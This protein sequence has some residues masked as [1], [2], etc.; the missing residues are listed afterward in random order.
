[1]SPTFAAAGFE[2]E[3]QLVLAGPWAGEAR[4]IAARIDDGD[5]DSWLLE[6]TAAGGAA[7]AA[8]RYAEAAAYYAAALAFVDASDGS[9]DARALEERQHDCWMR[10]AAE[11]GGTRLPAGW[12]FAA[13]EDK[14]P[15]AVID[16]GA[17][18]ACHALPI[19][20]A[21]AAH[22]WNWMTNCRRPWEDD[23]PLPDLDV[24]RVALIE[25]DCRVQA[26]LVE[27]LPAAARSALRAGD[28]DA[29]DRELHLAELFAPGTAAGLAWRARWFDRGGEPLYD[30]YRR[31]D[32]ALVPA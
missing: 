9:V 15:L 3:L 22:G 1:V 19:G 32:D 2:R 18:P 26:D 11:L 30:V 6:W 29:F 10:G 13:G 8:A 25:L 21:L 4:L 17:R 14:R 24:A 23:A 5:P 31:L 20:T 7:R 28:R 16:H 12:L 27:A